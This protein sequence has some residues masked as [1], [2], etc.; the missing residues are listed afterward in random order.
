MKG[1]VLGQVSVLEEEM[2][3]LEAQIKAIENELKKTISNQDFLLKNVLDAY[4][5]KCKSKDSTQRGDNR[6]VSVSNFKPNKQQSN[7]NS[8]EE[9]KGF[10]LEQATLR[11]G[12]E[13]RRKKAQDKCERENLQY[14]SI[15]AKV[16]ALENRLAAKENESINKVL[17][18]SKA[19]HIP[20]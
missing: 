2:L 16:D 6:K 9:D 4:E 5:G 11:E 12:R 8:C 15:S 13:R 10:C 18:A 7:N 17:W 1:T 14:A 19:N 20:S 3:T